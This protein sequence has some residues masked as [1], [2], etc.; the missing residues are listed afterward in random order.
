MDVNLPQPPRC[1][2]TIAEF[3]QAHRI[4][5]STL[6][7]LWREGR[8]PRTKNIGAKRIITLEAAAE[9]RS[10]SEATPQ[11]QVA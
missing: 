6:Y 7:G 3:C 5:R 4:S 2:F 11:Q 10:A 9:W 8:G 1:A